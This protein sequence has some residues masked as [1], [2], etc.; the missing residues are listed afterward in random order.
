[1]LALVLADLEATEKKA[2][3]IRFAGKSAD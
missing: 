1:M 3:R 2:G